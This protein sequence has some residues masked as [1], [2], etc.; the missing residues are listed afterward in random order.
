MDTKNVLVK[1]AFLFRSPLS[2]TRRIWSL[3]YT[4]LSTFH[5]KASEEGKNS[6]SIHILEKDG[7]STCVRLEVFCTPDFILRP[8]VVQA[9]FV[10]IQ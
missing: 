8:A 1:I 2:P 7:L 5:S 4:T 9:S 3:G 10:Q 6:D